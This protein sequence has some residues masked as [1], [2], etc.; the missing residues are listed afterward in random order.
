MPAFKLSWHQSAI[1]KATVDVELDELARW[2]VERGIVHSQGECPPDPRALRGPLER[3]PH[4][5]QASAPC[6]SVA[7]S[8]TDSR[9]SRDVS[10]CA[11]AHTAAVFRI[12]VNRYARNDPVGPPPAFTAARMRA[13]ASWTRSSESSDE[14]IARAA[15]IPD[16]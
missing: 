16:R 11:R 8:T 14:L 13:N 2:A 10:R 12:V 3:N 9:S 15:T 4:L 1:A 7:G 6:A 5:L